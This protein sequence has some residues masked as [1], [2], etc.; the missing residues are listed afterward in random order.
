[1]LDYA[2]P[3][4]L[5]DTQWVA[6]RLNEPKVRIVE[7]GYDLSDYNSGHI[8]G[9]VGWAWSVDFQH[10]VRKDIPDKGGMEELLACARASVMRAR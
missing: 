2:H 7:V 9:A 4:V 10:P 8:P 1:M 5:V 3:E 6:E